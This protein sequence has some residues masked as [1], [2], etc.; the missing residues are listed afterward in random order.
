MLSELLW[1]PCSLAE[2]RYTVFHLYFRIGL[3]GVW[4]YFH[5]YFVKIHTQA[6]KRF[7]I[8]IL[9]LYSCYVTAIV[10]SSYERIKT[11]RT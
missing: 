7:E 9:S 6:Y 10:D 1:S 4:H 3:N 5:M 8:A 2:V 11:L